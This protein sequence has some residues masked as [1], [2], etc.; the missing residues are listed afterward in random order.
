[1]HASAVH[2]SRQDAAMIE[3]DVLAQKIRE[4]LG[5]AEVDV[6]DL[7]GGKDH[8]EVTVVSEAFEGKSR[9]QQHRMIYN[10]LDDEM[11]G[12]IHALSLDTKTPDA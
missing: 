7:T 5:E 6:Q 4:A 1:M 11:D 10:A 12:A 8:F 9:I 3:P 2:D